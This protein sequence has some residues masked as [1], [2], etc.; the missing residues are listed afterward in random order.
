MHA[1]AL[2][3]SAVRC[4]GFD[5]ATVSLLA[6]MS[7]QP[8][9]KHKLAI[10]TFIK[11][12]K[13]AGLWSTIDY[14]C[15]WGALHDAQAFRINWRSPS[16]VGS[17]VNSPTFAAD[18]GYTFDGATNYVDTG[19]IASTMA[20]NVTTSGGTV[21]IYQAT[22]VASNGFAMGTG[23]SGNNRLAVSSKTATNFA[24]AAVISSNVVGPAAVSD[25]RGLTTASRNGTT[26]VPIYQAGALDE[27]ITV[28]AG[29][30]PTTS[31]FLGGTNSAGSLSTGLAAQLR[32]AVIAGNW[33]STQQAT[34][35]ALAQAC[36]TSIGANV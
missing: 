9:A 35:Y 14:M 6:A 3:L 2:S 28:V 29:V 33:S 19:W 4:G 22:N 1:H 15:G 26:S 34:F 8:D 18:G 11:G 23:T 12:L 24:G 27:T 30:L 13:A 5:P 16:L 32:G 25:A 17:A 10:D 20:L 21:G 36:M 31:V 7:V